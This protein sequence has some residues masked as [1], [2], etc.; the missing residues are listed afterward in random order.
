MQ[1]DLSLP[2][3]MLICFQSYKVGQNGQAS[4]NRKCEVGIHLAISRFSLLSCSAISISPS[5][6]RDQIAG[7]SFFGISGFV[8]PLIGISPSGDCISAIHFQVFHSQVLVS[9][10]IRRSYE[11]FSN[12][13]SSQLLVDWSVPAIIS[14]VP[15][16]DQRISPPS[17]S[18]YQY[19]S[20]RKVHYQSDR[21]CQLLVHRPSPSMSAFIQFVS[22]AIRY[23]VFYQS[24]YKSSVSCMPS[25][26]SLSTQ[27]W[28]S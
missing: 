22:P 15:G 28:F 21:L 17:V 2:N 1:I 8:R 16:I 18:P 13:C 27:Y 24:S 10:S 9:Q 20:I 3:R 5:I 6:P 12:P 26:P 25:M 4:P 11:S 19:Q 23:L 7:L 14:L